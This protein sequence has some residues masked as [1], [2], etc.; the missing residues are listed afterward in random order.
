MYIC[1]EDDVVP[2]RTEEEKHA[3]SSLARSEGQARSTTVTVV[4]CSFLRT[5]H[6]PL[7][8]GVDRG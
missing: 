5:F 2:W 7:Q 1:R 3:R 6:D 8:V 4:N